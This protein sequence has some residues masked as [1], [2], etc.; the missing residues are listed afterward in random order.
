YGTGIIVSLATYHLVVDRFYFRP[1]DIVAVKGKKQG[2]L[3]YE[4]MGE[5]DKTPPERIDLSKKFT[6]G[7]D[8]YLIMDWETAST[9]FQELVQQYPTDSAS[10]IYL[11]RCLELQKNP[12]GPD[13]SPL[14]R[15]TSK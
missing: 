1:L 4:L 11:E 5:I 3:L 6:R 7:F 2:V 10:Q 14:T 8:A 13:W 9:I 12:P 15:L